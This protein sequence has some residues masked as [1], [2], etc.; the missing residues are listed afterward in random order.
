MTGTFRAIL[1]SRD[2][3]KKQSVAVTELSEA[4]LMEGDVTVTIDATTVNYKD[5]LAITGMA[6]VVRRFPLV[7]GID[8]A[9]TVRDS[10]HPDWKP[11]DKVILNGWGTGET[12]HGAFAEISRVK[13]DWLVPLPDGMSARDAMAVGTAGYT[14]MLAVMALERH[15]ID[16][17]RGPVVVT[18]AAGGVGSVAIAILSR[19]GYRVIASTGRVSE[20]DYLV[21]LGATEIIAREELSGPAKPLAKERWAGGI[22]A[23]GS[24]TLANVMSMTSYGGAV[25]AC[26]LAGGMDLPTS[27][28]P[29]ILRGVSLLGID[30][31]MAPKAL[32]LEAWQRI[33]GELDH[34]KL[35]RL[36][37]TIGFD[38]I[39]QAGRDIVEGKIRGRVVVEM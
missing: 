15:G 28:A 9:G 21:D 36:S 18:G 14:A 39:L 6:P 37:T 17:D 25:A 23:V 31:V 24:H 16:R 7:P 4:D 22:D 1:V 12:H 3:N 32:R 5:G 38:D 29:F 27:V 33:A 10:A 19:L 20:T 30:S 11:G 8:F 26:G 35:A 2:E 13:G 34:Q